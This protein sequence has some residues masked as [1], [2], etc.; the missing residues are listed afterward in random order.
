M[1][2][3]QRTT[4]HHSVKRGRIV[5]PNTLRRPRKRP[6][7]TTTGMETFTDVIGPSGHPAH[8][9][10][11]G[12]AVTFPVI[13]RSTRMAGFDAFVANDTVSELSVSQ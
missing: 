6:L 10:G 4:V 11:K 13:K 8:D 1:D 12:M 2:S 9:I 5:N 3:G 7:F